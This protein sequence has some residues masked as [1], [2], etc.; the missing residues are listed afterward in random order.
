KLFCLTLLRSTAPALFW[1]L[2][3][4]GFAV[5]VYRRWRGANDESATTDALLAGVC[6]SA[7]ALFVGVFSLSWED[8]VFIPA[9]APAAM[10]F[11][12][13]V[14]RIQSALARWPVP[15]VAAPAALALLCIAMCGAAPILRTEGYRAAAAAIP[16]R[17]E[18][19]LM[20][21]SAGSG[22]EG[23]IVAERVAHDP[24]RSGIVLRA[25]RVLAESSW[26]GRRYRPLFADADQVRQYLMDLPVRYI[27]LDDS[28]EPLPFQK[29]VD[30]AIR[31]SP[32]DFLLLGRFPIRSSGRGYL[33]DV[34]VYE[35]RGAGER[36]PAVVRVRLGLERGGRTLE[37]RWK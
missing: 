2:A 5:A 10:L 14:R 15:A 35:N 8:R 6:V 19:R 12:F 18:G 22:G 36:R 17:P 37:Y 16:Y 23:A 21:V 24:W 29:L 4:V 31:G 30:E 11:A 3:A 34:R 25:S 20:L 9:L 33:G 7:Q 26:S 1:A 32:R 13:C 28:T 27:L